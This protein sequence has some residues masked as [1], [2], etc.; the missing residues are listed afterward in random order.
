MLPLTGLRVIDATSIWSGPFCAKQLADFGAEVIKVESARHMDIVRGMANPP[1]GSGVYPD[2][3]PGPRPWNRAGMFNALNTSKLSLSLDLTTPEG[4]ATLKRLAKVS[5]VVL[6]NFRANVMERFGLGYAAL[7]EVN[8]SIIVISMSANG[9]SGPERDYGAFGATLEQTT[10]MAWLTG[11]GPNDAPYR[12]GVNYPDPVAGVHAVGAIL[13]ALR[14]R[15]ET[16]KGQFIDLSQRETAACLVGEAIL[17]FTLNGRIAERVGNR[18]QSLAPHGCYRCKGDENW[19]TI[20]I[21]SDEQ[22]RRFAEAIGPSLGRTEWTQD[23]RFRTVTGRWQN[24]DE[25]DRLVESWTSGQDHIEVMHLL[26]KAGVPAAPVHNNV[27]LLADPH[28]VARGFWEWSNHPDAGR[29]RY[30]GPAVKLSETPGSIRSHSPCLGE[31]NDYIL[32]EILGLSDDELRELDAKGITNNDPRSLL[33]GA[34]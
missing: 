13:A 21:G 24:Q 31:H 27:E 4:V 3:D 6:D 28:L 17:D 15:R 18:H 25:L 10:G 20:A 23:E 16:G 5:D 14:Y 19:V 1:L 26:Q 30:Y 11:Y 7:R 34:R 29:H 12:G 32:R 33:P 9:M 22:W 8:P 2:R